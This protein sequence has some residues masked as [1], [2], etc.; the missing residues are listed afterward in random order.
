MIAV[1]VGCRSGCPA[2][3]IVA[4][5]EEALALL[6]D[7]GRPSG[8]FSIAAKQGEAGLAEAAQRLAL[9]LTF[10]DAAVLRRVA[11][12]AKSRSRRVEALFGL[13][14]VAET[15]AL[16]GAGQGAVLL[17]ARLSAPRATCAIAGPGA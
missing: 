14:S 17:V 3:D 8:L 11:G 7:G 12:V 13:P 4:L 15:A 2:E 1:G 5:V 16:A 10:L 9:P 6:P